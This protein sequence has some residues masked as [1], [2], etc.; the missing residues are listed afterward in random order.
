MLAFSSGKFLEAIRQKGRDNSYL[1]MLMASFFHFCGVLT[2]SILVAYISEF[3]PNRYLSAVGVFLSIYALLL[4]MAT[5]S[6]VWH[7]ARIF[8]AVTDSE[9]PPTDD[10]PPAPPPEDG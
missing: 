8:N 7:T 5:V 6:R 2:L 10:L 4:V 1:R 3:Y 9:G